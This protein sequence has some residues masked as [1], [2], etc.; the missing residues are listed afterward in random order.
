M[1][2]SA[3]FFS[4]K[5]LLLLTAVSVTS[6]Y[7]GISFGGLIISFSETRN[8]TPPPAGGPTPPGVSGAAKSQNLWTGT[9]RKVA[10]TDVDLGGNFQL[11]GESEKIVAILSSAKIDLSILEGMTV[12]VEGRRLRVLNNDLPLVIVEKAKF[13]FK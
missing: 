8:D 12:T 1:V 9:I 4:L 13:K 11:V 5:K 3:D 6:I 10:K 2:R 7:I